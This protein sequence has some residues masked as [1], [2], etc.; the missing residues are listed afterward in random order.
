MKDFSL[1][2]DTKLI[3]CNDPMTHLIDLTT[4]KKVLFVY[5]GGSVKTNGCFEDIKKAI[6][7]SGGTLFEAGQSSRERSSI[8]SGIQLA[9]SNQVD[10]VI[11]AGGA[12]VMDCAKLIAF[13]TYHQSDWWDYVK[14]KKRMA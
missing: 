9:I 10:L 5:G 3:F 2:N 7:T 11:G 12:S 6:V 4:N 1:R 8:E 14:E 13:G